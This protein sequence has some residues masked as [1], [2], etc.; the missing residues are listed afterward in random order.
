V[1]VSPEGVKVWVTASPTDGQANDAVCK[2]IAAALAVAP[3]AVIVRRGHT[4]REKTLSIAGIDL[5]TAMARLEK[6]P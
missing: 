4:A 2:A 1:E 3:S 6:S 5:A